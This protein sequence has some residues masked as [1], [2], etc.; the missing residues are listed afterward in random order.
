MKFRFF[1]GV[2]V[3][4]S[5]CILTS[6]S[7]NFSSP[8]NGFLFVATQG[9]S[10]VYSFAID[11]SS[12]NLSAINK[13]VSI[14]GTPKAMVISPA[15]DALYGVNTDGTVW[16]VPVNTDGTMGSATTVSFSG[17][18]QQDISPQ[19]IVVDSQNKFLFVANQ[20]LSTDLDSGAIL[21]FSISGG[22]LTQ[23]GA[24]VPVAISGDTLNP[25]P[26]ALAVTADTKFLYAANTFDSSVALLQIDSSGNLTTV[27]TAS[28]VP[29]AV[30]IS[31]S[32]LSISPDG[33]FL[34][35]ANFGSSEIS[36]FLICDKSV[37]TCQDVN[38]PDGTLT[39]VAS[40]F[41]VSAGLGPLR[42][43]FNPDGPFL[44]VVGQQSNQVLGYKVSTG[45]G[46]LTPVNNVSTGL[47]PVALVTRAGSARNS[48]GSIQ[49]Y[50]YAVNSGAASISSFNYE[51]T[52]G[53]LNLQTTTTTAGQ[54]VAIVVK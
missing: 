6:C 20:G 9:D 10:S 44:F 4:M 45:S 1:A 19:D 30:G 51:S 54:P 11:L 33:T 3:L 36:A 28:A 26:S 17:V 8:S 13:P 39:K 46:V 48:D 24:P 15:G 27:N 50:L 22:G 32:G 41:P 47:A 23:V 29:G 7:S 14:K 40:G 25:G 21:V 52:T 37:N 2:L 12:G 35:V 38:N 42:M 31:P 34:Y 43:V 49:S 18:A 53:S 5:I 16:S